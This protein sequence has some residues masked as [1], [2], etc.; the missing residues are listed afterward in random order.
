MQFTE[1]SELW[2]AGK[3]CPE[4]GKIKSTENIEGGQEL[5]GS[6]YKA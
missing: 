6:G 2:G 5:L 4:A 3:K 1:N